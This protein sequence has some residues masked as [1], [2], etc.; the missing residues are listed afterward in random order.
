[1]EKKSKNSAA[2]TFGIYGAVGFQLAASVGAGMFLGDWL[3]GKFDTKPM[4][5]AIGLILGAIGGFVNLIR[6]LTW[7]TKKKEEK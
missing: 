5:G 7:H 3:D 1:M 2:V 4:L 6:I